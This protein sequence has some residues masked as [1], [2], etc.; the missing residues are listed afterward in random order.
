MSVLPVRG[1]RTA[2]AKYLYRAYLVLVCPWGV[3]NCDPLSIA[4]FVES[5]LEVVLL[6]SYMYILIGKAAVTQG[7]FI[8]VNPLINPTL[9]LGPSALQGPKGP[10]GPR[11]PERALQG[12]IEP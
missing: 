6:L 7:G 3:Y 10:L 5:L 1:D 8:I 2:L 12:P 4:T 11:G 9:R